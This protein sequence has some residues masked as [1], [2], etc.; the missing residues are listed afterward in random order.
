MESR[1][2]SL[3]TRRQAV[4]PGGPKLARRGCYLAF[5]RRFIH[6]WSQLTREGL[7]EP[8]SVL[9]YTSTA[10]EKRTRSSNVPAR[11]LQCTARPRSGS[12]RACPRHH[13]ATEFHMRAC[14]QHRSAGC[15]NHPDPFHSPFSFRCREA[16]KLWRA[17]DMQQRTLDSARVLWNRFVEKNR[18]DVEER[19]EQLKS[20]G[21][22][23]ALVAGFAVVAF[24]EFQVAWESIPEALEAV[25]GFTTALVVR[26]RGCTCSRT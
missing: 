19:A 14:E 25:F 26:R 23:S 24:L 21:N 8:F 22:I 13:C 2:Q 5:S 3:A 20:I 12:S 11:C 6:V 17:E 16:Q 1:G 4:A 9:N 15:G 7:H 10:W 18:R